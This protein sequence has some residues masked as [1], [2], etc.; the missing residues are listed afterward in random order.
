[1]VW[2]RTL[3]L[4]EIQGCAERFVAAGMHGTRCAHHCRT[5]RTL[6]EVS[7]AI[8]R[9]AYPFA[10][11]LPQTETERLLTEE[12]ERLGV[13]VERNVELAQFSHDDNGVT[14]E[15]LHPGDRSERAD[16][17][18]GW[19]AATA[20]TVPSAT[21]LPCRSP[22]SPCRAPGCSPTS[23]S[24]A[25][26]GEEV[27][28]SWCPDG[29]LAVF[30]IEPGPLPHHRRYRHRGRCDA[31]RTRPPTLAEV[32]ALVDRRGPGG[33]AAAR[34]D[35]AQHASAS[36]NARSPITAWAGSS[37]PATPRISTR[38]PAARA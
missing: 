2:P 15:L 21:V 10:L 8:A 19:P 6:A 16:G 23:A 35:L 34:P 22:A 24:T 18:A 26:C 33:P 32:Q 38:R 31:D 12:L 27:L 36:T 1:M 5:Q 11:F 37:S 20:R 25:R 29:V 14:A 4:L 17:A 30:P 7:L 28:I 9:S 13:R 3:E